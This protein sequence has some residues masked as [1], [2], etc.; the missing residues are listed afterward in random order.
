MERTFGWADTCYTHHQKPHF[1]AD[2]CEQVKQVWKDIDCV[3]EYC[4]NHNMPLPEEVGEMRDEAR[5]LEHRRRAAWKAVCNG[6]DPELEEL[7][8]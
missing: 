4:L 8:F 5:E 7:E 1:Y 6:E 3:V 2:L